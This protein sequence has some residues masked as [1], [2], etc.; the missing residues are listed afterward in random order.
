[1]KRVQKVLNFAARVLSGRRK[2]DHVSD[3]LNR[4][5]WLTAEHMYLYH[6]LSLL[7][8]MICVSEPEC[9]ARDLI[10]RG[11]VHH[12]VTR[13]A[14][15]FITPAIRSESG[16]RR[17]KHSIVSAYNALP[18]EMRCLTADRFKN[19]LKQYLLSKQRGG[20]G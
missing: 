20:V 17:F 13:N 2:F 8:R 9:V 4:L 6:G 5:D 19:E 16:R 3:V 7:K 14:D 1:M 15:H 12:R 11:D 10:T 18:S